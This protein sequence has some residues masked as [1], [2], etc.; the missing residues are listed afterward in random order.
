MEQ[1]AKKKI[2][3]GGFM[4][5]EGLV[6]SEDGKT[7]SVSGGLPS[8][9]T[10]YQQLVTDGNGNAKWED[11]PYFKVNVISG[12][13]NIVELDATDEEIYNAFQAGKTVTV[14]LHGIELKGIYVEGGAMSF[15]GTAPD[16]I[17]SNGV[18][19]IGVYYLTATVDGWSFTRNTIATDAQ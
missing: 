1:N 19:K 7:L 2:S 17:G 14:N 9:G 18:E 16:K 5:G 12:S 6:L 4:L 13:G 15:Y 8:G 10:P 3:C 11:K